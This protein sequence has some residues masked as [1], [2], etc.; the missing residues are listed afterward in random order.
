MRETKQELNISGNTGS[1][2]WLQS[3]M[4]LIQ[5]F[6]WN[7]CLLVSHGDITSVPA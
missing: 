5:V 3:Q 4:Q 1:S 7:F 6:L 2:D